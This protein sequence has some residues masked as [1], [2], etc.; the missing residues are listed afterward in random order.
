MVVTITP[1]LKARLRLLHPTDW[2]VV[3]T[4]PRLAAPPPTWRPC[5]N[6][7]DLGIGDAGSYARRG[8]LTM[9]NR[10]R[11][12]LVELVVKPTRQVLD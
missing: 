12:D 4:R 11:D 6:P 7:A 1:P 3:A 8:F 10:H 2:S 9:A 5:D